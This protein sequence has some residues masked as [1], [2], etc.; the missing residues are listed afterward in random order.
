[1][2][3]E[4]I[5]ELKKE[6]SELLVEKYKPRTYLE[7]LSDEVIFQYFILLY[8]FLFNCIKVTIKMSLF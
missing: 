4:N 7:L 6:E 8:I 3:K 5:N 2:N 1:M